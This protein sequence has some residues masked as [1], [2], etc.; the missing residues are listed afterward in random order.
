MAVRVQVTC[1]KL[2]QHT[3]GQAQFAGVMYPYHIAVCI[4]KQIV[5]E[6]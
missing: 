4:F 1:H 5:E 3:K 2:M 6:S